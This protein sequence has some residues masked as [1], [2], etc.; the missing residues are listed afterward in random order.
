[1]ILTS[2]KTVD[3][4]KWTE[5]FYYRSYGFKRLFKF[6]PKDIS[7]IDHLNNN[8]MVLCTDK[9]DIN[10]IILYALWKGRKDQILFLCESKHRSSKV[11]NK[12]QNFRNQSFWSFQESLV[13][14]VD[15]G[16]YNFFCMSYVE[17][18]L[19]SRNDLSVFLLLPK[20]FGYDPLN[21]FIQGIKIGEKSN[22]YIFQGA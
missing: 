21:A 2:P 10:L 14:F 19:I 17:S 11:Y 1:M 18:L 12:Y 20:K 13:S 4:L 22:F 5:S 15:I 6:N 8:S 16:M 7:L 9:V 3:F